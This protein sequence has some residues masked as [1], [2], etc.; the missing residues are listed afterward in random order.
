MVSVCALGGLRGGASAG[1]STVKAGRAGGGGK[2]RTWG[3]LSVALDGLKRRD[4]LLCT[5]CVCARVL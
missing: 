4:V 5:V 2:R 1:F 3:A